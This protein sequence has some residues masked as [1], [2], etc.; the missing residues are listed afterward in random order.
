MD[1]ARAGVA[2]PLDCR[3]IGLQMDDH[4]GSGAEMHLA[5]AGDRLHNV[6]PPIVAVAVTRS[7]FHFSGET[8]LAA[9]SA[10][11]AFGRR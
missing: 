10:F 8:G 9:A 2:A 11:S 7:D 5:K 3:L 4:L 1:A 6:A